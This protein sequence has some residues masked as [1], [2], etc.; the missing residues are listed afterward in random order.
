MMPANTPPT[1]SGA[2]SALVLSG[3]GARGAYQVGVIKALAEAMPGPIPFP[4]ITGVSVGAIN[5]V[6]LAEGAD[7]FGAAAGKLEALWRS[8]RSASVFVTD[9]V[10]LF[11]RMLG[12]GAG[13]GLRW[14]GVKVPPSLLDTGPL[15]RL[16]EAEVDFS[17]IAEMVDR[18][19]LRALAVTASSYGQG[20][21]VTFFHGAPPLG[22][23]SRSRRAG[24]TAEIGCRHVLA[25]AALPGIFP[26]RKIGASWYGDGAL[27]QTA[28]LSPAIH[29]GC[30]R[31]LLIAARDGVPDGEPATPADPPYPSVGDLGGQMLDIIFNDNLDQD[32]ERLMRINTTLAAVSEERRRDI[33]LNVIA[34]HMVRPSED[35]R[36]F[37]G[38]H[39]REVPRSLRLLLRAIGALQPPYLLPSY[40]AFEP[41]YVGDLIELGYRD[42]KRSVPQI[43]AFMQSDIPRAA[44]A[45]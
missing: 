19:Y 24:I 11:G 25:S 3:G 34:H 27:R 17:R 36:D 26:A 13:P 6:V 42:G 44:G 5:A 21:S 43:T 39:I 35:I 16:L 41:G 22:A 45:A 30:D 31:L 1:C 38:R 2:T 9:P 20:Q 12:W 23:W 32:V 33:P 4:V 29:L 10:P 28:P 15:E 40:L 37:A 8:L 7:D 18:D 14:A